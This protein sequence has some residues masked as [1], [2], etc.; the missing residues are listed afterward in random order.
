MNERMKWIKYAESKFYACVCMYVCM[1]CIE[2]IYFIRTS[3]CAYMNEWMCVCVCVCVFCVCL[4]YFLSR[5]FHSQLNIYYFCSVWLWKK[6]KQSHIHTYNAYIRMYVKI[7]QRIFS[8]RIF[9]FVCVCMYVCHAWMNNVCLCVYVSLE[10]MF[11]STC[12]CMHS[13][14][15]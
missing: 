5:M 7:E 10:W 12:I 3:F 1:S 2:W 9:L 8:R 13:Y 4:E 11:H 14:H 15:T 6:K